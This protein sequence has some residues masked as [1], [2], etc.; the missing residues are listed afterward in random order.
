MRLRSVLAVKLAG[1]TYNMIQ[2]MG[3]GSGLTLP[4][5][6]ARLI[7]PKIL[8]TMSGM[9]KKK[10]I[11]VMGTNG[12]T[13]TN[14]ILYNVLEEEGYKVIANK[15]G[16]N[17]LNGIISAFVLAAGKDGTIDADYACI[18]VDENTSVRTLGQ[19]DPDYILLTNISRDQLDRYGE[20]DTIINILREGIKKA[21]RAELFINADDVL[22]YTLALDSGNKFTTF[23][24]NDSDVFDS[25]S[26]SEIKESIF[27]RKCGKKLT[28]RFFHYGQLGD[29]FCE[30]CGLERPKPDFV[31]SHA[32]REERG[33]SFDVD[34][35][36]LDTQAEI[37]YNIYN[38]ASAY[39]VLKKI[40]LPQSVIKKRLEEFD[41]SNRRE[42]VFNIAGARVQLHLAKNPIGFQHKIAHV[43]KDPAPKDVIVQIND[44]YQDGKDISWL[45]DVDF[46]DLA[47]GNVS[48]I[49]LCGTRR[50]DMGLRLKY[51]D[52]DCGFADNIRDAADDLTKNGTG[53]LYVIVNY[54]GIFSTNNILHRLEER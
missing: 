33:Y 13:T 17:M 26:R 23:G 12:K 52:I 20:V 8:K 50:Y 40:G 32:V 22:S 42:G 54:S 4:G 1:F 47:K 43:L 29:Y 34:G 31:A 10:T 37:P 44:T 18:E 11:V 3:K 39:A 21:K 6:I 41:Y 38:T 49:V 7:D 25:N 27:C 53:N 28:Y 5:Y 14:G 45:W 16:S 48:R 9:V 15:T 36:R 2:K 35:I 51:E 24:I 19:L 30:N 46:H